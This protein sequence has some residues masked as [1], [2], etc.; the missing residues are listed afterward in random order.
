MEKNL[1]EKNLME[2]NSP[3]IYSKCICCFKHIQINV[4]VN[5]CIKAN[6]CIKV[7]HECFINEIINED[8]CD[9]CGKSHEYCY[10]EY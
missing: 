8:E 6:Q 3:Q 5:Q 4:K 9:N 10:C 7:C 2:K 1:M